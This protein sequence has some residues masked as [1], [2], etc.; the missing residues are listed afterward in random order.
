M[1]RDGRRA[2]GPPNQQ[3]QPLGSVSPCSERGPVFFQ[4][5]DQ[6]PSSKKHRS[7]TELAL[8]GDPNGFA[9]IGMWTMLGAQV[10]ATLTD[11]VVS[12]ADVL[13][14][15]L[16]VGL[17]E[18]WIG[19]LVDVGLLHGHGHDCPRCDAVDPESWIFH[20]WWALGYDKAAQVSVTRLKMKELKNAEIINAVW[21][22]DCRDPAKPTQAYC[23]YC[24]KVVKRKDTRSKPGDRAQL[25]H[26]DPTVAT[27]ARNIVVACGDCNR[28][29]GR[30]TP[31][32]ADMTLLPAPRQLDTGSPRPATP[33]GHEA[34]THGPESDRRP[35]STSSTSPRPTTPVETARRDQDDTAERAT[36]PGPAET[37]TKDTRPAVAD[38]DRTPR[39]NPTPQ[40]PRPTTV[41][42]ARLEDPFGTADRDQRSTTADHAPS[43]QAA[44]PPT[45]ARPNQ[46]HPK[47]AMPAR[48]TRASARQAG[49]GQGSSLGS[50]TG[51]HT[52]EPQAQQQSGRKRRRR[53]R[54]GS[55]TAQPAQVISPS[56][57]A[58]E[59]PPAPQPPRWD[60]GEAPVVPT[61]GSL[62]SPYFGWR[63]PPDVLDEDTICPDHN[64]PMPCR[65]CVIADTD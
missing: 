60:A 4:V 29:K 47:P 23:R 32:Q 61:A 41:A 37:D 62:G 36:A 46:D 8:A 64:T 2:R 31:E 34:T 11:G 21:A 63:G 43:T 39:P 25:D 7:L 14:V 50:L 22:R 56:H 44:P 33:T 13:R 28:K 53:G 42:P 48:G 51:L 52:A 59:P 40:S 1:T 54:R 65:R 9:A 3:L 17:A 6:L 38:A 55:G 49:S 35:R 57:D 45:T 5:D 18:Q 20:D 15:V 30:R 10:Q 27:G 19:L 26:V 24:S 58:G 16:N 12:R